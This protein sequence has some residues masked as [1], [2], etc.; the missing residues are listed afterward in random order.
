MEE[1]GSHVDDAS[2]TAE[3]LSMLATGERL[4]LH[5]RVGAASIRGLDQTHPAV[6]EAQQPAAWA[7]NE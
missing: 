4:F 6:S 7:K 5:T 1:F 3:L 2:N